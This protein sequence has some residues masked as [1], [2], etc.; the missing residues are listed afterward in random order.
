ME[1]LQSTS[2]TGLDDKLHEASGAQSSHPQASQPFHVVWLVFAAVT[3]AVAGWRRGQNVKHKDS[4]TELTLSSSIVWSDKPTY[5]VATFAG[6]TA[7]DPLGLKDGDRPTS[8]DKEIKHGQQALFSAARSRSPVILHAG[9]GQY[10]GFVPDLQRRTLMNLVVTGV[11]AVPALVL[12]GGYL[13]YFYPNT[14]SGGGGAVLAGDVNGNPVSLA[15]WMKT[16]KENEREL[17][18]GL[19]GEAFYIITTTDGIKDFSVGATCTHLGCVVPWNRA[20]NRFC[21]PCHGSQYDENGKVVRGPAPLSLPLA[22]TSIQ[23]GNIAVSPWP[24]Q[25]FRTGLNPWWAK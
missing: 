16:H 19:K 17:V 21:C 20:A 6:T 23:D 10:T 12:L 7:F 14:G 2:P 22:H 25:D 5:A 4:A 1:S 8:L 13:F 18:Q 9:T 3:A 15:G 24:E 11:T